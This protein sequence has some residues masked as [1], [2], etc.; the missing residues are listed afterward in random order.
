MSMTMTRPNACSKG[1]CA[2][3]A[4][5]MRGDMSGTTMAGVISIFMQT[6]LCKAS[7]NKCIGT[8]QPGMNSAGCA[9]SS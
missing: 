3:A 1:S 6:I 9:G 8:R 5:W 2:A 4:R 7:L